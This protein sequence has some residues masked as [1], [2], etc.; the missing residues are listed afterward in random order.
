[1]GDGKAAALVPPEQGHVHREQEPE[2]SVLYE[3]NASVP[4]DFPRPPKGSGMEDQ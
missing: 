1:M 2:E 3:K 4:H